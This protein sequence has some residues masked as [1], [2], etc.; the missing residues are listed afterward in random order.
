MNVP[1]PM[2][3]KTKYGRL[4]ESLN[5]CIPILLGIFIVFNPYPYVTAIQEI[6]FYGSVLILL[7]LILLKKTDYS[8]RTPLSFPFLLFVLWSFC[9][10]FFALNK[11]NSIHDFYAHLLK[12]VIVFYLLFNFFKTK[13]RLLILI[14]TI[15]ISTAI[16]SVWMMIYYY[17][18][19][20]NTLSTKLGLFMDE[21]PSNIVG[22]STLFAMILSIYQLTKEKIVY[23]KIILAICLCTTTVAT[24]ATQTRGA[25]LAMFVSLLLSFPKNRKTLSVFFLF[26]AIAIFLM[27]VKDILT[28]Q[29]LVNR[30]RVGDREQI[31]YC[32]GE[33]IKDHPITGIGFGMQTYF[34]ENLLNNCNE[35]VPV[36]YRQDIPL[37]A[38]HNLVVDIAVRVGI[39]G[40]LLFFYIVFVFGRMSWQIIKSE[41]DDFI[42]HWGSCFVAAFVAVF[43]QGLFENTMS[44]PPAIIFYTIMAMITILWHL[45]PETDIKCRHD[46]DN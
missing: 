4:F 14:W 24:L 25:I 37:K 13:E 5:L 7:T 36:E 31:W 17:L 34:D 42:G 15:V 21:I 40:L 10:L 1:S 39:V 32:F 8:L 12:Y 22:I 38:P 44:G 29:A 6:S 11:E 9:G 46:T 35:R 30:I 26:L 41:K 19:L 2:P 16:Y 28:P 20:G 33:I 43:I 18:I 23:R 3:M 45:N 27:P